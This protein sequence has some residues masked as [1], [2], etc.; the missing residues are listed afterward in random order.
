MVEDKTR[1]NLLQRIM[2]LIEDNIEL[3][4]II[5]W[6]DRT[7]ELNLPITVNTAEDLK[8]I[9]DKLYSDN[10]KNPFLELSDQLMINRILK[11]I[12]KLLGN[13]TETEDFTVTDK[14]YMMD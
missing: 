5:P 7:L 3:S 1:D 13:E 12:D 4:L 9:F 14:K 2:I 8:E 11:N 6:V 10:M